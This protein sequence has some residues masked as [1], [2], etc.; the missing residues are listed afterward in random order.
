MCG[1]NFLTAKIRLNMGG[2]GELGGNLGA[3]DLTAF[4]ILNYPE[5]PDS[6]FMAK[7]A[8]FGIEQGTIAGPGFSSCF[9]GITGTGN[10]CPECW[11]Q[12]NGHHFIDVG[13]LHP[14]LFFTAFEN[15]HWN[16]TGHVITPNR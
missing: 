1:R 16:L 5:F 3:R 12:A 8:P 7:F 6:W 13:T 11:V 10:R 2:A 9:I 14:V 4:F 15:A